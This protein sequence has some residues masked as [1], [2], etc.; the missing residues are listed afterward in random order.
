MAIQYAGDYYLINRS[1]GE[2]RQLG[3]GRPA[4]SLMFAKLSP[5]GRAVAYVSEHNLFVEDVETGQQTQ[6]TTDGTRK[7][8]NG[9]FDWVYEEEFGCRTDSGGVLIANRLLIGRWMRQGFAIT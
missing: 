1:T 5:N 2:V 7:R 9:T 8:I 4:Q 3:K 6:L